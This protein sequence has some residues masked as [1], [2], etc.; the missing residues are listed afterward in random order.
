MRKNIILCICYLSII[1]VL[2][3]FQIAFYY[4]MVN[5]NSLLT[6]SDANINKG[7]HFLIAGIIIWI[8]FYEVTVIRE[9]ISIISGKE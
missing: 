1:G 8:F 4:M 9:I 5:A 7:L 2:V 3:L 6:A